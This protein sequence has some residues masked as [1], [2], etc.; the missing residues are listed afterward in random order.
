MRHVTAP[1]PRRHDS[2]RAAAQL[3]RLRPAPSASRLTALDVVS[4][5]VVAGFLGPLPVIQLG[6]LLFGW[7]S[8]AVMIGGQG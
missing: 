5:Q 1:A 4:L 7:P 2:A 6:H 3:I 8:V